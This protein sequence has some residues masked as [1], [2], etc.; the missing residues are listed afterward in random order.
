MEDVT[1]L[2][3]YLYRDY[4]PA[5][6]RWASRD[7]IEEEGGDN[8]YGFSINNPVCYLDVKGKWVWPMILEKI[9]KYPQKQL[10]KRLRVIPEVGGDYIPSRRILIKSEQIGICCYCEKGGGLIEFAAAS[11]N[12][13]TCPENFKY[14]HDMNRNTYGETVGGYADEVDSNRII[15]GTETT[16]SDSCPRTSLLP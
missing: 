3:Y 4:D 12:F 11:G 8:I 9:K 13:P 1:G 10:K 6:G 7:P 15:P 14:I 5:T 16:I 2:Y